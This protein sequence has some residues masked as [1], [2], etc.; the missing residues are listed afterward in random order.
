MNFIIAPSLLSANFNNLADEIAKVEGIENSWLHLDIMDG[1]FVEAITFGSP[2]VQ[3]IRKTTSLTF[4]AHLMVNSPEKQLPLFI[5]AGA[6]YITFHIEASKSP[7]DLIKTIKNSGRKT[8][9]SLRPSTPISSI[10]NFLPYI[11]L[12]LIMSV[13]PGRSGQ[14]F[15]KKSIERIK[16]IYT[17][18][19]EESLKFLISVDGG[20]NEKTAGKVINAGAEILVM[21]S[22]FFGNP[23]EKVKNFINDL[24]NKSLP[25]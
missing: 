10:K 25:K 22:Y 14:D 12:L 20:I 15:K 16:E 19:Q 4:D 7:R 24:R 6:D 17:L 3:N 11:D 5:E 23:I 9:I 13:E 18:K 2:V 1:N 8:G 21:G